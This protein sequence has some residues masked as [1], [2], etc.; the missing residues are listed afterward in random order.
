VVR[1]LRK[2]SLMNLK[3]METITYLKKNWMISS[4]ITWIR[5]TRGVLVVVVP[6]ANQFTTTI[7]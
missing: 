4:S 5:P 3:K 1:V 6:R 7:K 2:M